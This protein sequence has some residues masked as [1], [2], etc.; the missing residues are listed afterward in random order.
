MSR[1]RVSAKALQ[2]G[3]DPAVAAREAQIPHLFLGRSWR[4]TLTGYTSAALNTERLKPYLR[5]PSAP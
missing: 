1:L 2:W 3:K 5:E 4:M